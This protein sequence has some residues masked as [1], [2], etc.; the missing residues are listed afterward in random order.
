MN[1]QM[2]YYTRRTPAQNGATLGVAV[3]G[4]TSEQRAAAARA[5]TAIPPISVADLTL[6]TIAALLVQGAASTAPSPSSEDGVVCR[7]RGAGGRACAV[8]LWIADELYV[9]DMDA[10]MHV[11]LVIHSFGWAPELRKRGALLQPIHDSANLVCV[12]QG[13]EWPA[14]LRAQVIERL[15]RGE[16]GPVLELIDAFVVEAAGL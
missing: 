3:Q 12:H 2:T 4:L 7:Y 15:P 14:A 10:L 1:A 5:L 16:V 9:P 6:R 8:G 13:K 11:S